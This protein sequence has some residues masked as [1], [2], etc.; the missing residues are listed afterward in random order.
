VAELMDGTMWATSEGVG[1]GST[2]RFTI[3]AEAATLPR[4]QARNLVGEQ[5]EL[6]G[7]R[8]LVVDDNATNRRILTL[9]TAK[10]GTDTRATASAGEALDW[11]KAGERFDLAIL[12]MHMPVMDGLELAREIR[13]IKPALPLV[14]FSSLSLRPSQ[15]E[16]GALHRTGCRSLPWQAGKSGSS[17]GPI[18]LWP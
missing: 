14:L 15:A 13:K 7:K 8:I 5:S 16:R 18:I 12:D 10:W 11:L 2:F 3:L 17:Q 6:V 1:K 9:Q 4:S